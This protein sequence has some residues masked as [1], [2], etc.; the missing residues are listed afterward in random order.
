MAND[1]GS[2]ILGGLQGLEAEDIQV[3]EWAVSKE[4][5]VPAEA[6]IGLGLP[7]ERVAAAVRA[8]EAAHLLRPLPGAS[9]VHASADADAAAESPEAAGPTAW[10]PLDPQSASA[11]VAAAESG[12]RRRLAD[13]FT[14]W[15]TMDSLG[16][17][18]A[19]ASPGNQRSAPL[20]VIESLQGV[21]ALIEVASLSC[22]FEVITAQPGGGRPAEELEQAIDRDLAMVA[23]GVR[24]RTLY[25]H[26]SRYHAPT[27]VYV[28]RLSAIGS[29]VRTLTELPGR[30]IA[31]DRQVVL[32]PHATVRGGAVAIRDP[33]TVTFLCDAFERAW[34]TATPFSAPPA[35]SQVQAS[36]KRSILHMLSEGMRDEGIARRL[37]ISLRTCR[38]YIA[39]IFEDLGAESR[40]QAGYLTRDRLLLSAEDEEE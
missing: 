6:A 2:D 27:Q 29:Q 8:L 40:F 10:E 5:L 32:L 31:F 16:A 20:Q 25:Q 19:A 15:D 33:S 21:L 3:Y 24:M 23:R 9:A 11:E 35:V 38:K 39:E 28:E 37:G 12:L 18:F 26:A 36:L 17:I 30:M 14:L 34:N 13:I 7:A 4:G 22:R 1:P